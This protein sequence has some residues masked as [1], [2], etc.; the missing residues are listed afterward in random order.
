MNWDAVAAV[1]D[2]LAAL[3][4]F[5]S[6]L[7]L[8]WQVRQNTR[9]ARIAAE[10]AGVTAMREASEPLV[11]DP[12]LARIF[13]AGL[14][15]YDA[16]TADEQGR[17]QLMS[18][19][20]FKAMEGAHASYSYG[21]LD[22][23]TWRGWVNLFAYYM[24]LPGWGRYWGLRRDFFAPRFQAFVDALPRER[25]HRTVGSLA[26]AEPRTHVP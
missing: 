8:A 7:Y 19:L 15:D 10:D 13:F 20:N 14:R 22:E 24:A 18:F 26:A 5:G 3:A 4:V 17:F 6:L 21:I 11:Q 2:I 1:A 16:L 12:E 25:E 23:D 9:L